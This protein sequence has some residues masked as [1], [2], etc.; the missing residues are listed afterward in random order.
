MANAVGKDDLY[1]ALNT[2]ENIWLTKRSY[3]RTDNICVRA[4]QVYL[5]RT[6]YEFNQ[7]YWNG[8]QELSL[9][10]YAK[11]SLKDQPPYM[12]VSQKQ[13]DPGIRYT[14]GFW[15][16]EEKCGVLQLTLPSQNKEQCEMHVW[17]SHINKTVTRCEAEY[18]KL[19]AGPSYDVYVS[20][21]KQKAAQIN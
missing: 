10:L 19:C 17:E 11:L 8:T 4:S 14:L 21:C 2:T 16:V 3:N 1:N 9:K 6:D 13:G 15:D 12:N 5:N 7:S 20:S 18:E